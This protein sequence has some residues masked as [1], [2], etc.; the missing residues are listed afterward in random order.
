VFTNFSLVNLVVA[1]IVV[2]IVIA[3]IVYWTRSLRRRG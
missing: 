3:M 2:A 1:V